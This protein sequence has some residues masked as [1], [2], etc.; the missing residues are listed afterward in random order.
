MSKHLIHHSM[1]A[2]YLN[3]KLP[4]SFKFYNGLSQTLL[5]EP[6]SKALGIDQPKI[7]RLHYYTLKIYFQIFRFHSWLVGLDCQRLNQWI[8]QTHRIG[9][10]KTLRKILN[11]QLRNFAL[12]KTYESMIKTG[13]LTSLKDCPC[14][15]Y[16][17][18]YEGIVKTNDLGIFRLGKFSRSFTLFLRTISFAFFSF[19][20][21][22]LL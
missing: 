20:F 2:F 5:G 11:N 8:I 3:T 19:I 21:I 14:G 7:D 15:Y 22:R 13:G 18:Q 6:I 1:M 17:K 16:Q 10:P 12:H 9:L 4:L